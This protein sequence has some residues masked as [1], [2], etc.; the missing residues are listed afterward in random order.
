MAGY[1]GYAKLK[2]FLFFLLTSSPVVDIMYT[3]NN[4]VNP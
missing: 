1:S 2:S 3:D 4:E